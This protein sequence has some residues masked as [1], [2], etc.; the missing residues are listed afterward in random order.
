MKNAA[1]TA[2]EHIS[3]NDEDIPQITYPVIVEEPKLT[4]QGQ[5]SLV[6]WKTRANEQHEAMF[7]DF[8]VQVMNQEGYYVDVDCREHKYQQPEENLFGC[9]LD[10]EDLTAEQFI[11][12]NVRIEGPDGKLYYAI[13]SGFENEE[14]YPLVLDDPRIT[15]EG[16]SIVVQW[17]TLQQHI[18]KF[19]NFT[20]EAMNEEGNYEDIICL[21][22]KFLEKPDT[23]IFRCELD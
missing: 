14:I 2:A 20:V 1:S 22:F 8:T 18:A 9:E 12:Y 21:N 23:A 16:K 5:T 13:P 6:E 10:H 4:E 17:E 3:D 15:V 7:E 19:D 11:L